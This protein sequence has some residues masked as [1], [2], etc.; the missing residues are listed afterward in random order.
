MKSVMSKPRYKCQLF[1][2][3]LYVQ[4]EINWYSDDENSKRLLDN[5]KLELKKREKNNC[6]ILKEDF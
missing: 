4:K 1:K 6:S 5:L 3:K 2:D